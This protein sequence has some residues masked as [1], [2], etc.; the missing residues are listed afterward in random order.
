M[1]KLAGLLHAGHRH[2]GHAGRSVY[3]GGN[4]RSTA[5]LSK[6]MFFA[7]TVAKD[8]YV[9]MQWLPPAGATLAGCSAWA[10]SLRFI[11]DTF[12]NGEPKDLLK[13]PARSAVLHAV[14]GRAAG[15]GSIVVGVLPGVVGPVV[16][17]A[18]QAALQ[19]PLLPLQPGRLAWIQPATG[20]ESGGGSRRRRCICAA[21]Q[22]QP[23]QPEHGARVGFAGGRDVFLAL[24]QMGVAAAYGG[25]TGWLQNGSL[26]RYLLLVVLALAAG[27][28][29]FLGWALHPKWPALHLKLDLNW[30]VAV[31]ACWALPLPWQLQTCVH[32]QRLL[33][34]VLLGATGLTVPDLLF[35]TRPGPDAVAGVGHGHAHD[36]GLALAAG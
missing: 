5:S 1:R 19:A 13:T 30:G 34:L 36:A 20:D 22:G 33:A 21:P 35:C 28:S 29:P 12:F 2:A 6:E 11:H 31:V 15:A 16:A 9:W 8:G 26:Q 32:R 17:V 10:Y 27:V 14:A 25:L 7:E 18:A 24:S 3:G 4:G 23:A